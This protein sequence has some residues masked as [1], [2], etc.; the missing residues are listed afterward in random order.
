MLILVKLLMFCFRKYFGLLLGMMC[1][2]MLVQAGYIWPTGSTAFFDGKHF[3]EYTQATASGMA[4]SALFG[5]TR[6]SGRRFHEGIDIAPELPRQRG[7]ATDPVLA[8]GEGRVAYVNNVPGNSSYG[9]YLIIEHD[10]A[11]PA[12]HTLYAHMRTITVET[13]QRIKSGDK[14]GI[15]GRSAGGYV[16]P[17]SRAH[18]HFEMGLRLSDRFQD[19]Y[20]RQEFGSQNHHGVYNGMNLVGWDPL[21]YYQWQKQNAGDNVLS[22]IRQLPVGFILQVRHESTP[23]FLRRYP[24]LLDNI[25]GEG[26]LI[27]WEIQFTAWGLP[28]AWKALGANST[29]AGAAPGEVRLEALDPEAMSEF[30]CRGMVSQTGGEYR[31]GNGALRVVK[32]LFGLRGG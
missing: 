12:F 28:I 13:G 23:D 17:Q 2:G 31:L 3:S 1:G 4:E 20:D 6:N 22:Y 5:C 32:L 11:R 27:G 16:I 24:A 9:R 30:A 14:V 10:T 21:D 15:M 8:V 25:S 29:L 26:E 7:E 18:L 19:W